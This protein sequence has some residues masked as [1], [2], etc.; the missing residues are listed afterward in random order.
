[1]TVY[2]GCD[3]HPYQQTVA[4]CNSDDGVINFKTLLHK[5][6][7]AVRQFYSQSHGQVVVGMEACGKA[8]WFEALVAELGCQLLIGDPTRIRQRARSRHKSDNRDAELILELLIHD[9]FPTLWRRSPESQAVLEQLRLRHALVQQRTACWNH[10]QALARLAGLPRAKLS[11]AAGRQR[12]QS[13]ALTETE[14]AEVA[15]WY[16]L[17]DHLGEQIGHLDDWLAQRAAADEATQLL[18]THPGVGKLTALGVMHTLGDVSR[19]ATAAKVVAYVGLDPVEHSSGERRAYG[20]ISKAGS[21]VLRFLLGQAALQSLKGDQRLEQ[22]YQNVRGRRG[23]AKAKVAVARKLLI[24]CWIMLRDQ[25][26]YEEFARRGASKLACP[27][28]AVGTPS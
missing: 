25:I 11:S 16:R 2:I 6:R 4:F 1:M 24:R 14:R 9:E 8:R 7:E 5:E 10:L 23:Q 20:A 3:F 13:A 18:Q 26:T 27:T 19:F 21:R 17:A 22:F 28:I 12:L 15:L